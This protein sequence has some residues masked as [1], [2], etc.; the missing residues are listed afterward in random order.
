MKKLLAL[1]LVAGMATFVACGPSKADKEKKEKEKQDS[2]AAAEKAKKEADSLAAVEKE[3]RKM[4]SLREDS[5]KKAKNKPQGGH[6]PTGNNTNQNQTIPKNQVK[7]GQ[8]KG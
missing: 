2:I 1:V 3:K 5:I 7:A 6:K 4:D 8:G